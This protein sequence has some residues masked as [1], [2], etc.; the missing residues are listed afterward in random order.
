MTHSEEIEA[1]I[2]RLEEAQ[3]A[4]Q[5]ALWRLRQVLEEGSLATQTPH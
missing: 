4:I 1:A 2:A 3:T 5:V